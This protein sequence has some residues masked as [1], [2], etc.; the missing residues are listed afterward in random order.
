VR[1]AILRANVHPKLSAYA[2]RAATQRISNTATLAMHNDNSIFPLCTNANVILG[3]N[4]GKWSDKFSAVEII[5]DHIYLLPLPLTPSNTLSESTTMTT[6][7]AS[8]TS[9]PTTTPVKKAR[10]TSIDLD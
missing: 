2:T 1:P 5:V 7:V 8:G 6:T 4:R 9:T 10:V 3:H